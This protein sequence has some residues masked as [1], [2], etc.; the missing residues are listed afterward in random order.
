M[1]KKEETPMIEKVTKQKN[2]GRVASGKRVSEYNRL[3]K[4]EKLEEK[5]KEHKEKVITQEEPKETKEPKEP[6]EETIL[7]E[8]QEKTVKNVYRTENIFSPPYIILLLAVAAGGCFYFRD[9]IMKTNKNLTPKT[10]TKEPK[11]EP[12]KPDPFYME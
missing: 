2:P 8:H 3:K 7:K 12:E 11:S 9:K 6:K 4:L 1:E 5:N 10:P